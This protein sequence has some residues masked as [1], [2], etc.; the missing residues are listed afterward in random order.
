MYSG[1]Y[2]M[3]SKFCPLGTLSS[4][5]GMNG[6]IQVGLCPLIHPYVAVPPLTAAPCEGAGE[7]EEEQ[8]LSASAAPQTVPVSPSRPR[9][10]VRAVLAQRLPRG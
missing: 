5:I 6:Q 1:R 7:L 3:Y 9:L 2:I 10:H 8:A 4:A